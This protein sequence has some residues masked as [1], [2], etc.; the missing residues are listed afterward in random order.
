[1]APGQMLIF[2]SGYY[3]ILGTQM[4]YFFDPTF[5]MRSEIPPPTNFVSLQG[6]S[7]VPQQPVIQATPDQ[8]AGS[9][10]ARSIAC[11]AGLP[12]RPQRRRTNQSH[13]RYLTKL[14]ESHAA[15]EESD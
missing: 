7:I 1:M 11:R 4:L 6:G 2:V 8:P 10:A 13:P 14:E 9:T 12:G 5:K 3:P 15:A